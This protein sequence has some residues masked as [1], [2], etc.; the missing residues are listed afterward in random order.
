[1]MRDIVVTRHSMDI[2][3]PDALKRIKPITDN[4]LSQTILSN[5]AHLINEPVIRMTLSSSQTSEELPF[6]VSTDLLH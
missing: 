5:K 4:P 1:M 3:D 2:A 6:R